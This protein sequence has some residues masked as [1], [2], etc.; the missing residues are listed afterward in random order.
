[1]DD[2]EE[3]VLGKEPS[4]L[5]DMNSSCPLLQQTVAYSPS[6]VRGSMTLT[7][8]IKIAVVFWAPYFSQ[9]S[10]PFY[11]SFP[12]PLGMYV[13]WAHVPSFD[14]KRYLHSR[15]SIP[16]KV[17]VLGSMHPVRWAARMRR[18]CSRMLRK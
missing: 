17:Q 3:L 1:M 15:R 10:S 7:K 5:R 16:Y 6:S 13:S 2:D 18:T 4:F 14:A 9:Q 8:K 11:F 12:H